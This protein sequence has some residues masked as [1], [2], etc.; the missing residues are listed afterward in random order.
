MYVCMYVCMHACMY[1]IRIYIYI[2]MT[3]LSVKRMLH[4]HVELQGVICPQSRQAVAQAR[5]V[6]AFLGP[7]LTYQC[8]SGFLSL[9]HILAHLWVQASQVL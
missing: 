1:T 4:G 9:K 8:F 5:L 2:Y 6:F 7:D 3:A